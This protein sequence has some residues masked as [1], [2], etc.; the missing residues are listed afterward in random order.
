M[1][2]P[3]P[4]GSTPPPLGN[5]YLDADRTCMRLMGV[6]EGRESLCGKPAV[7]HVDWGTACGFV[8]ADHV[9]DLDRWTYKAVHDLGSA[10]GMPGALWWDGEW[11]GVPFSWCAYDGEGLPTAEP[12]RAIAKEI[13]A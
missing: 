13:P 8:C 5:E 7:K 11:D 2:G 6:F 4:S 3:T 9:A 10:C 12:V 1:T